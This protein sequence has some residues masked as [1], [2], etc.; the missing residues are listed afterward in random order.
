MC[1][2]RASATRRRDRATDDAVIAKAVAEVVRRQVEVGIDVVSDGEMSKIS[3]ATYI[4]RALL[5]LRR[6]YAARAGAGPGRV[7]RAAAQAGRARR[8]SEISPAALR[9]AGRGQGPRA[10][11]R[12]ISRTCS[13]ARPR[14]RRPTALPQRGLARRRSRSFSRTT[15]TARRMSIWR[16]WPRRCAWNTRPSSRAGIMLQID[17][18]DLAMGRHTM[19]RDRSLEE[20]ERARGAAHRGAEPRA[21]K[22]AGGARAHA[23]VLGQLRGT[24][25][26]RRSAGAVA[27]G[28]PEGQAAGPAVRGGQSA[29]RARMGGVREGRGSRRTRS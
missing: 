6:R 15:T 26:S 16:P 7:S 28:R 22:H 23:R 19:Y 12:R 10:A 20:F 25:P 4:A 11:A 3:Y 8:D 5:R 21:A 1:C 2:S 18:P 29:P 14:R 17:A 13:A 9:R 24:A 27:A